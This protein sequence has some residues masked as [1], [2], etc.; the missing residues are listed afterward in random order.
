MEINTL[1]IHGGSQEPYKT[2]AE[3]RV[4]VS[5]V[6]EPGCSNFVPYGKILRKE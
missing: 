1:A 2:A 6:L 4:R 3:S 5:C